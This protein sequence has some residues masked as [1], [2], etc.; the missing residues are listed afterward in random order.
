M[1]QQTINCFTDAYAASRQNRRRN[2]PALLPYVAA[3]LA[4][5]RQQS[6]AELAELCTAN[7]NTLFGFE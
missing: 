4:E 2:E 1:R 7:A 3:V 6:S 5:R